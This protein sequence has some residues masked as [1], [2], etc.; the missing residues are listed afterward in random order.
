[1][2]I[3]GPGY[4]GN[5][6]P[7]DDPWL[8]FRLNQ[9]FEAEVQQVQGTQVVLNVAGVRIVARL[10]AADQTGALIEQRMA[11]FQVTQLD[12][13]N[14][15]L[16]HL[17][18]GT[19]AAS[20]RDGL[21]ERTL[22]RMLHN[23]RLPA[24][25]QNVSL[26]QALMEHGLP[27]SRS[28]MQQ[29]RQILDQAAAQMAQGAWGPGEARAAAG[30]LAAGQPL[31]AESLALALAQA[32]S[33]ADAVTR[34]QRRLKSL[35]EN[36]SPVITALV[37]QAEGALEQVSLDPSAP[38]D[39]QAVRLAALVEQLGRSP[40]AQLLQWLQADGGRVDAGGGVGLLAALARLHRALSGEAGAHPELRDCLENIE[41]IIL[42]LRQRGLKNAPPLLPAVEP[43]P[44]WIEVPLPLHGA[45]G[46]P[47]GE[48]WLRIANATSGERIDPQ[49]TRLV[50]QVVFPGGDQVQADLSLAAGR[51]G[52]RLSASTP[53]LRTR[54]EEFF[55]DLQAAL[56]DQGIHLDQATFDLLPAG[57][58]NRAPD[59]WQVGVNREV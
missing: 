6:R 22:Q 30:L 29:A 44:P 56:Q 58:P 5:I 37:R 51:A 12:G 1:M 52:M 32:A 28:G 49:N 21:G 13:K 26:L 15:V 33:L 14:L 54:A 39:A 16:R 34:L 47:A 50:L 27:V 19:G 42:Q 11:R 20:V 25:A 7:G 9:R 35:R 31:S 2:N 17:G 59:A 53:E 23:L 10:T 41:A 18:A 8:T 45:D 4:P 36:P 43:A 40:E 57:A 48:A 46:E 3:S 24:D 55:P 38:E